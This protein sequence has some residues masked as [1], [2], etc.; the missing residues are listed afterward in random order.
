ME[1]AIEERSLFLFEKIE[2]DIFIFFTFN[3][4]RLGSNLQE[5]SMDSNQS[6]PSN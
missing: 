6:V 1:S 4:P 5:R 2:W 3:S